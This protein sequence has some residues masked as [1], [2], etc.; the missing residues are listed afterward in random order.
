MS[1]VVVVDWWITGNVLRWR[2]Q[3]VLTWIIVGGWVRTL[4]GQRWRRIHEGRINRVWIWTR[5][6]NS[7]VNRILIVHR[8]FVFIIIIAE[9]RIKNFERQ[10]QILLFQIQ[11]ISMRIKINFYIIQD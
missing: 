2:I 3:T 7:V 11:F 5:V 6:D 10:K 9:K 4:A 1:V 8:G